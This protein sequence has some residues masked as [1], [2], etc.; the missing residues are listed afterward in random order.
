MKVVFLHFGEGYLYPDNR[1]K[2]P[3]KLGQTQTQNPKFFGFK[4]QQKTRK[5]KFLLGFLNFKLNYFNKKS[6]SEEFT[7]LFIFLHNY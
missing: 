6:F 1:T 5:P 3:K 4:T 7:I 2:N